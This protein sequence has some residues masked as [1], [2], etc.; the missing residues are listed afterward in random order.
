MHCMYKRCID[1]TLKT[2]SPNPQWHQASS[3]LLCYQVNWNWCWKH[4]PKFT[5]A[6]QTS[7][8]MH[9]CT[10]SCLVSTQVLIC[11]IKKY[12]YCCSLMLLFLSWH[13][14]CKG[15]SIS[16]CI[17][18]VSVY[19]Q[20]YILCQL[21]HCSHPCHHQQGYPCIH[22]PPRGL[23]VAEIRHLWFNCSKQDSLGFMINW[24]VLI[25]GSG[26]LQHFPILFTETGHHLG[27]L[28]TIP[29]RVDQCQQVESPVLVPSDFVWH[30]QTHPFICD[31]LRW[32]WGWIFACWC[33]WP[34][35]W[36]DLDTT[37]ASAIPFLLNQPRS[38][39]RDCWGCPSSPCWCYRRILKNT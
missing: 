37:G 12:C 28:A 8:I 21:N 7:S 3:T 16:G 22:S 5:R 15:Y 19:S 6:I 20:L 32:H 29:G 11:C 35:P 17:S 27:R 33:S 4:W 1:N 34:S 26:I 25:K 24:D 38:K 36:N 31:L 13:R 10:P 9:T 18:L 2:Q 14:A 23:V 39:G 30:S